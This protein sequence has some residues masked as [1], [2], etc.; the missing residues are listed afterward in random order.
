MLRVQKALGSMLAQLLAVKRLLNQEAGAVSSDVI[1]SVSCW[2]AAGNSVT[3]AA[4]SSNQYLNSMLT[5][6]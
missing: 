5:L 1:N 4:M 3:K 2:I 6:T